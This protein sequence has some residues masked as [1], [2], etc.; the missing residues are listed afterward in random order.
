M[1]RS[2]ERVKGGEKGAS[3][4]ARTRLARREVIAAAAALFVEQGFAATTV[5]ALSERSDIPA[6]TVY[7]LFGSKLG[8]L[9]AWLDVAV[10]G[11]DS[12]VAVADRPQIAHLLSDTDA[13]RLIAGFVSVVAAINGRTSTVYES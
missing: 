6:A 1:P 3:G 9:K 2:Q 5:A 7:R 11:D 13:Q 10:G 4:Q 12:P 8:I